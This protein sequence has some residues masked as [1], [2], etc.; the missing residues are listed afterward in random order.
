MTEEIICHLQGL[1]TDYSSIQH[2]WTM[3]PVAELNAEAPL[4]LLLPGNVSA[5]PSD[6]DNFVSQQAQERVICITVC[7]MA[8]LGKLRAQ[9]LEAM[10]GL[11]LSEYHA[12]MEYVNGNSEGVHGDYLWWKDVFSADTHYRS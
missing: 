6:G 10:I 4:L 9:L 7:K 12:M 11:Q 5:Q 8:D 1:T 2:A 3:E